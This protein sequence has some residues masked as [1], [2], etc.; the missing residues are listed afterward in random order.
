MAHPRVDLCLSGPSKLDHVKELVEI[1]E[2]GTM[3]PDELSFMREFGD[4]RHG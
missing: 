4:A 1:I 3:S 2:E